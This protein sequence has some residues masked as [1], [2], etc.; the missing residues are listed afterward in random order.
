MARKDPKES[1]TSAAAEV[2][3]AQALALHLAGRSGVDI[4]R[5]LG[6][7]PATVSEWLQAPEA[8]A[9]RESTKAKAMARVEGA[10]DEAVD[11]LLE[12]MRGEAAGATAADRRGA[13]KDLLGIG[14]MV[15]VQKLDHS[16]SGPLSLAELEARVAARFGAKRDGDSRD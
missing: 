1:A 14:G 4:A 3:R 13:A 2:R 9:A 11:T 8:K 5:E 12:V 16:V 10:L 7:R 15:A 6:V